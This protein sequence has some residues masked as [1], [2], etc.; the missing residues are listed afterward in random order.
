MA[1]GEEKIV[2]LNG[3]NAFALPVGTDP[4]GQTASLY[5]FKVFASDDQHPID[6]QSLALKQTAQEVINDVISGR[7]NPFTPTPRA[8][9]LW[10]TL[11]LP[12]RVGK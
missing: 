7:G 6:I 4:P 10:T 1:P 9:V 8:D 12:V 11:E 3:P 2:G 5:T